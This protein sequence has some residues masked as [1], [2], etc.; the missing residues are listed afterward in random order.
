MDGPTEG[1]LEVGDDRDAEDTIQDEWLPPTVEGRVPDAEVRTVR[2]RTLHFCTPSAAHAK[3]RLRFVR[4]RNQEM[5]FKAGNGKYY[6]TDVWKIEREFPSSDVYDC[7]ADLVALVDNTRRDVGLL[8]YEIL[9]SSDRMDG[10]RHCLQLVTA[11]HQLVHDA[12]NNRRVHVVRRTPANSGAVLMLQR[13]QHLQGQCSEMAPLAFIALCDDRVL[14]VTRDRVLDQDAMESLFMAWVK[15]RRTCPACNEPLH[16]KPTFVTRSGC[17]MHCDCLRTLLRDGVRVCPVTG[18]DLGGDEADA[19]ADS[20]KSHM[21][22]YLAGVRG[23][24]DTS[25]AGVCNIP[26]M[27]AAAFKMQLSVVHALMERMMVGSEHELPDVP[28]ESGP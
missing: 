9:D 23:A 18:E 3:Q 12:R 11:W 26:N 10:V 2:S 6:I 14:A 24:Q 8:G 13:Q 4:L 17:E 5:Q 16:T 21:D 1:L 19:L 28:T 7:K 20:P 25:K 27:P 15:A 22:E